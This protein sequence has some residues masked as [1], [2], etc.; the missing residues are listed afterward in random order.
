MCPIRH[1]Y[2]SVSVDTLL[3][4]VFQLFEELGNM[5]NGSIADEINSIWCY[6]ATEKNRQPIPTAKDRGASNLGRM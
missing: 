5:E 3:L 1:E 6:Q 2:S 4:K